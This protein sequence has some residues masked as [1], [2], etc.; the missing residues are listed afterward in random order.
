MYI[1]INIISEIFFS[2][3]FKSCRKKH[4]KML[5]NQDSLCNDQATKPSVPALI[6][7]EVIVS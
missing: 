7:S 3:T 6:P 2:Y 5:L 1:I 4:G